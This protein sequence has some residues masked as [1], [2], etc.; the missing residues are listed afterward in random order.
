MVQ[1]AQKIK[2]RNEFR[3][4]NNK[5]LRLLRLIIGISANKIKNKQL[6][7]DIGPKIEIVQLFIYSSIGH[8]Y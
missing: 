2:F 8:S 5:I 1:S 4:S 3:T 6:K 7:L